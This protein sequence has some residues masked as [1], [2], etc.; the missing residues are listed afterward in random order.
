MSRRLVRSLV[1]LTALLCLGMAGYGGQV[2]WAKELAAEFR[3]SFLEGADDPSPSKHVLVR[4]WKTVPWYGEV[5]P[6]AA[7]S[8]FSG[9][10][11]GRSWMPRR[12]YYELMKRRTARDL[13]NDPGAWEKWLSESKE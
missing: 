7:P 12:T 8:M 9:E 13:G 2:W 3:Y 10:R 4:V 11:A 6:R 1:V 5:A